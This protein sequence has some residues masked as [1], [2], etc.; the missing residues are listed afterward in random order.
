MTSSFL[1]RM[2]ARVYQSDA[3]RRSCW[4]RLCHRQPLLYARAADGRA[5][6]A[7]AVCAGTWP[8]RPVT[9]SR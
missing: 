1:R 6:W 5:L 7:C 3:R 9:A 4:C 8:R 2:W